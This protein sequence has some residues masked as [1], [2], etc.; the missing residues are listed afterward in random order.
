MHLILRN[1]RKISCH[2]PKVLLLV[3]FLAGLPNPGWGVSLEDKV[4]AILIKKIMGYVE[5]P[6]L[7]S[8]SS[9]EINILV[10]G[11]KDMY[12]VLKAVEGLMIKGKSLKINYDS[13]PQDLKGNQVLFISQSLKS[14]LSNIFKE[15]RSHSILTVSD[16][17][18]F[19]SSGG[20]IHFV[21][22]DGK[23]KFEINLNETK[24]AGI[25]IRSPLLQIGTIVETE[26]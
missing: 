9:K 20:M 21:K 12:Q 13:R 3:L 17:N 25:K 10:L 8:A 24:R 22:R 15:S 7:N 19:G 11:N 2:W 16:M 26:K 4:K 23:I 18:N 5:W 14:K 6:H 1:I